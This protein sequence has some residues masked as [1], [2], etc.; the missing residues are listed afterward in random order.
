MDFNNRGI[1]FHNNRKRQPK[2]PDFVGEATID[3]R[4]FKLAAWI[5]QGRRGEFHSLAFTPEETNPPQPQEDY[6]PSS[7]QS[8]PAQEDDH[9]Y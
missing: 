1:L 8:R 9:A 6:T 5:K 3:G 2:H 4:R 7:C